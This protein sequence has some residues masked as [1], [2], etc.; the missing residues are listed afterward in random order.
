MRWNE[1]LARPFYLCQ[2]IPRPV[3]FPLSV[4]DHMLRPMMTNRVVV[5]TLSVIR[6]LFRREVGRPVS[7]PDHIP[8]W[9]VGYGVLPAICLYQI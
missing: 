9:V 3:A 2:T 1:L 4:L 7:H 5:L 8:S 6:R